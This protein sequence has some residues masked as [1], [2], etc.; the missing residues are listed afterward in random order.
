MAGR[1]GRHVPADPFE[2]SWSDSIFRLCG[3]QQPSDSSVCC[4]LAFACL[5]GWEE[6]SRGSCLRWLPY[7]FCSF[8]C[9]RGRLS[10]R[11]HSRQGLNDRCQS[12]WLQG[13][14]REGKQP[15]C[16]PLPISPA[17]EPPSRLASWC[18]QPLGT[19]SS[20]QVS[21]QHKPVLLLFPTLA[22]CYNVC[23]I[24]SQLSL[25]I[26]L[27]QVLAGSFPHNKGS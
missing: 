19:F 8:Q 1:R 11:E 9:Q 20:F 26:F 12:C 18:K 7:T 3:W 15:S 16:C 10:E 27:L 6:D 17:R 14:Q 25:E 2:P 21:S 22:A 23:I 4:M 5:Q 24:I 13:L